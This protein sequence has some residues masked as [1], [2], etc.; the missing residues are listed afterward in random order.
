[1]ISRRAPLSTFDIMYDRMTEIVLFHSCTF[2]RVHPTNADAGVCLGVYRFMAENGSQCV[3]LIC[4]C[5]RMGKSDEIF[6]PPEEKIDRKSAAG[7]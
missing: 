1:M 7:I 3:V 6:P 2:C 5:R 4:G